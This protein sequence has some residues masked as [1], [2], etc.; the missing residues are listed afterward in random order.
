MVE[1][2]P[3]ELDPRPG[4]ERGLRRPSPRAA[5]ARLR[6]RDLHGL[7]ALA[8]RL[9]PAP[10]P[11]GQRRR[12]GGRE[13]RPR[14]RRRARR[15]DARQ[16]AHR[17][18]AGPRRARRSSRRRSPR[19]SSSEGDGAVPR[20]PRCA[21]HRPLGP[22]ALHRLDPRQRARRLGVLAALP[23]DPGEARARLRRLHV[24]VPVRRHGSDRRL[25]RDAGGEPRRVPRIVAEQIGE[26]AE[27]GRR[28]KSSSARRRTSRAGSCSRWS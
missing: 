3:Q 21:G 2:S 7:A 25:R 17:R 26:I 5:G 6:R 19:S 12:G 27:G 28:R 13:R 15:A 22:P 16:G 14:P 20:L 24:R 8:R 10:L 11:A 1:D 9:P 23:G 4:H 18:R